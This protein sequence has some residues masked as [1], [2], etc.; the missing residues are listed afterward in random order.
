MS[1]RSW[2]PSPSF[3]S[4]PSRGA[5]SGARRRTRR[6]AGTCGAAG[7]GPASRMLGAARADPGVPGA[8]G[9]LSRPADRAHRLGAADPR[10]VLPP[11][12][13]GAGREV[14]AHRAGPSR[15]AGRRGHPPVPGRADADHDRPGDHRRA[16]RTAAGRAPPGPGSRR[17]AGRGEGAGGAAV[18]GGAGHGAGADLLAGR[19]GQV[20]LLPQG[21]PVRRPGHHRVLLRRQARA[22]A[23][24]PAGTAGP[25]VGGVRGRQD[26]PA[27]PPPTTTTT[28]R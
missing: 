18:R 26:P 16:G 25:T 13:P 24:V 27:R 3:S 9:D 6:T 17:P 15:A 5:A 28:P 22:G 11:G 19:G 7:R 12:R 10:G 8:A 2:P 1:R 4:P 14:P 21:G 20:L 23:P